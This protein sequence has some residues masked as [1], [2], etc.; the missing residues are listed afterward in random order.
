MI[1]PI[2]DE[3]KEFISGTV[4]VVE[5]NS[6]ETMT[7]WDKW[8]N[9]YGKSWVS[10]GMGYG[11]TIGTLDG[12]PVCISILHALVEGHKIL[13]IDPTSVV[14][15]HD[16]IKDWIDI[17]LPGLRMTNSMNFSHAIPYERSC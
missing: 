17:N 1:R 4:G 10:H 3:V 2:S 11:V 5:A 15:D 16:M 7:L 13:F 8:T 9:V 6:Y 14:V 12:R